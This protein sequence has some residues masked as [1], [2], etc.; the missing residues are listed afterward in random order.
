M[1]SGWGVLVLCI[2]AGHVGQA[3]W[4]VPPDNFYRGPLYQNKL[5]R[6]IAPDR[7]PPLEFTNGTLSYSRLVSLQTSVTSRSVRAIPVSGIMLRVA[8][9]PA[10]HGIV[11]FRVRPAA[12]QFPE[13]PARILQGQAQR[14]LAFE[15]AAEDPPPG[16]LAMSSQMDVVFTVERIE[17]D[18]GHALYENS[19]ATEQLWNALGRPSLSEQ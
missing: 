2:A 9:G 4:R 12:P 7:T 5:A 13:P 16:I 18:E 15:L 1:R 11:T 3:Q 8:Y 17:D 10:Q 6:Y 14:V 19:E